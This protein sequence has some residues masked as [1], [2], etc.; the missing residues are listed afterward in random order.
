MDANSPTT[1]YDIDDQILLHR[2]DWHDASRS[3]YTTVRDNQDCQILLATSS[4][5]KRVEISI[6]NL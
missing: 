4:W 6:G 1:Q 3:S 5:R 2:R